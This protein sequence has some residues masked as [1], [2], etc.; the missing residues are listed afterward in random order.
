MYREGQTATNPKTGQKVVFR[1][2]QWVNAGVD[3]SIVSSEGRPG[4]SKTEDGIIGDEYKS[5][6]AN[7]Q[8]LGELGRAAAYNKMIPGGRFAARVSDVEQQFPTG[9]QQ[10]DIS[11]YQAFNAL[12]G[13]LVPGIIMGNTGGVFSAKMMDAAAEAERAEKMAPGPHLEP[14]ANRQVIDQLGQRAF[15]DLARNA[16]MRQWR[17]QYGS[18]NAKA[19]DGSTAES[20]YIRWANSPEGR[21]YTKPKISDIL[22]RKAAQ[23]GD[24]SK[25]TDYELRAIA[26]G[27]R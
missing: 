16:F 24:L 8:F 1:D 22:A 18:V 10:G 4:V 5:V 20:A 17:S 15:S 21:Q 12:K 11:N 6:Q 23:S 25:M 27:R 26:E 7:R 3:M 2:G 19:K 9:W 14:G 13:R